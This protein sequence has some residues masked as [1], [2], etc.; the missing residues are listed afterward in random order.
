MSNGLHCGLT[1]VCT[2]TSQ[3]YSVSV[4]ASAD[5][6]LS[7]QGYGLGW[8]RNSYLDHDVTNVHSLLCMDTGVSDRISHGVDVKIFYASLILSK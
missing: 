7:I 6:E 2:T 8:F 4:G 3:S 1:R 5:P